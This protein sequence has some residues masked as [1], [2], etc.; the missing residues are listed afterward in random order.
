MV[1]KKTKQ[2]SDVS[3]AQKI[4]IGT[5]EKTQVNNSSN[6]KVIIWI[7]AIALVVVL[8]SLLFAQLSQ[9]TIENKDAVT[10]SYIG[11]FENGT[12]FDTN[13]KEVALQADLK[14]ESYEPFVFVVGNGDV[15][16]GFDSNVLGMK[17]GE[18]KKFT[19][20]PEEA[21]GPVNE[22]LF[23]KGLKRN[24]DLGRYSILDLNTY[25]HLFQ[26]EAKIGE[27]LQREDIPWKIQVVDVNDTSV[28]LEH[29]LNVGDV[30]N[31]SGTT[32]DGNVVDVNNENITVLQNPKVGQR[33]AFPTSNGIIAGVVNNVDSETYDLDA[34]HPLAGKTLVFEVEVLDVVSSKS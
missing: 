7:V 30:I 9:T 31:V 18:K 1:K 12:V 24:L 16:N 17:K 29:M 4:Q 33:I 28:K 3:K 11:T 25:N 14:R 21:Y 2:K 13:V 22:R 6:K 20:Q 5:T 26:N 19:L 27:T 32:W 23:I 15:V 34:N 8:A 10:V